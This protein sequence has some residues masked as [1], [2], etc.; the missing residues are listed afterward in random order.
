MLFNVTISSPSPLLTSGPLFFNGTAVWLQSGLPTTTSYVV[1]LD[2]TEYTYT[3]GQPSTNLLFS[4]DSLTED[5][6]HKVIVQPASILDNVIIQMDL[7]DQA[8]AIMSLD[9]SMLFQED[10]FTSKGKWTSDECLG[11][12]R[13]AGT[14]HV[15]Q[16]SGSEFTY[17]FEGDAI[18]I[19]G[20]VEGTESFY[21][22]SIDNSKSTS[23][24]PPNTSSSRP[25]TVLA[26]ASNL[27]AGTHSLTLTNQ[28]KDGQSRIEIDS[29]QL[30]AKTTS[31]S[32]TVPSGSTSSD[33]TSSSA[34]S[35]S[36]AST[37]GL[38]KTAKIAIIGGIA[39]GV[40][41]LGA[42]IA[43]VVLMRRRNRRSAPSTAFNRS[44]GTGSGIAAA[45][46]DLPPPT[47]PR[48]YDED[49]L[50]GSV[51]DWKKDGV[52]LGPMASQRSLP[53]QQRW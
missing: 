44:M 48:D 29:V 4:S 36:S 13:A 49:T 7:G 53:Y 17:E 9:D 19:W 46:V 52:E 31:G 51:V 40:I 3:G 10:G 21:T 22:V 5:M 14:C 42:L 34:T 15:S 38:S 33:P 6:R 30:Y 12:G 35:T 28:P 41:L 37:T 26:H 20:A 47:R 45:R 11:S 24:S 39:C 25:I 2:S 32:S 23:Y 18:T 8:D 1:N 16:G 27:G 43:F 50:A